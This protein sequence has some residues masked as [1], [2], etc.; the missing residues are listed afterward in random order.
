VAK[1]TFRIEWDAHEYEHKERT[2]DWYWAVGIVGVS[3]AVASIIFG[4]LIFGFLLLLCV[5]SLSLY[6]NRP[7]DTTKVVINEVGVLRGDTFYPYS[8]LHSFW[9][10]EDHPH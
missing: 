9:I 1:E 8:T 4:N 7:P 5:F 3:G 6:I 2:S 10:D